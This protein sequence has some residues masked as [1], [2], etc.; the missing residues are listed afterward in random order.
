MMDYQA[1]MALAEDRGFPETAVW[2][3]ANEEGYFLG[4]LKGFDLELEPEPD[5]W[6]DE[7]VKAR[8]EG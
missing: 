6:S 2:M 3:K 5:G 8:V 7:A 4:I 1:V